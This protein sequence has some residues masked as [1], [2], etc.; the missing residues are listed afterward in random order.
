MKF[1]MLL[2]KQIEKRLELLKKSSIGESGFVFLSPISYWYLL[3]WPHW[4]DRQAFRWSDWL[5]TNVIDRFY[6]SLKIIQFNS[7]ILLIN[8]LVIFVPTAGRCEKGLSKQISFE[9]MAAPVKKTKNIFHII[10]KKLRHIFTSFEFSWGCQWI[11]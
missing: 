3:Y 4:N 7:F 10:L 6:A 1:P 2:I 5:T 11:R 9:K 8:N